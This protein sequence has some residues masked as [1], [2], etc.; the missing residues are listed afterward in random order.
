MVIHKILRRDGTV[1]SSG[2]V[3]T[4]I[5]Q[6]EIT[7]DVSAGVLYDII[8]LFDIGNRLHF[9]FNAILLKWQRQ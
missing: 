1:I 3:G 4:A 2:T 5:S 7:W 9:N 8:I 6:A